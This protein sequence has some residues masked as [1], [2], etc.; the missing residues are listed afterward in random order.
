M[1]SGARHL[2]LRDLRPRRQR[3]RLRALPGA[4]LVPVQQLLRGGRAALRA[5]RP[6][7]PQ[8]PGRPRRRGLPRQ[9]RRPDARPRRR[10]GR[11]LP[12]QGG[13]HDRAR[14][15][16]RA[17]APGAAADGHQARPL[18]QPPAAGVRRIP[19][20]A[21]GARPAR[22]GRRRGWT[23]RDRPRRRRL[24]LRQRAPPAQRVAGAVSPRRPADHQRRVA[25]VHPRRGLRATRPLA[26]RR[27]GQG[28]GGA[29]AG[30]VLLDRARRRVV[31]AHPQRH[32][33]GEPRA[34][35]EPRQLL[36]GRGVRDLG[37][38]AAPERGR[39][40]ARPR[41]RRA[42]RRLE[43]RRK[44]GGPGDLPSPRRPARYSQPGS[45][46]L[47]QAYG[48]C[49][50]WTSS[51]YHPYPGFHPAEGAI[52]EYNGKFMSNQMVLRGGCALTPPGHARATYRNF[53]PHQSRW[54]LSGVRLA[55][56][57]TPPPGRTGAAS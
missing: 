29:L 8:P 7:P 48:D 41:R 2:V 57:G 36:R 43:G 56:G 35:R 22:L 13:A 25:G 23:G 38:Q 15:P 5:P 47:R 11:R 55:D 46:R 54:A 33:A 51:A 19:E 18:P 42:G 26:L 21:V 9:R 40:G 34:T 3:A 49:W 6:R 4:V 45:G 16:P 31:R 24:Q 12:R 14:V 39:V 30:A 44:P 20:R 52:G 1:A 28:E 17:A 53:F 27:L 32:L 50:E 10:P 37:R